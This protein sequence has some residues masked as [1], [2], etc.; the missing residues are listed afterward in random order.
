MS[1]NVAFPTGLDEAIDVL[2]CD[3][4]G[5]KA[6]CLH[7]LNGRE[8]SLLKGIR[9]AMLPHMP[10]VMLLAAL[11][12]EIWEQTSV[13][14]NG[15]ARREGIRRS[16]R[17]DAGWSV[18]TSRFNSLQRKRPRM[19]KRLEEASQA[20][21]QFLGPR[22]SVSATTT[23]ASASLVGVKVSLQALQP[24]EVTAHFTK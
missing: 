13:A 4:H 1:E 5:E 3:P 12:L 9:M 20:M 14:P 10:P 17:T 19:M 23:T 6:H 21:S 22:T 15:R 2:R 16:R 24:A 18:G 11:G 7:A 8:K